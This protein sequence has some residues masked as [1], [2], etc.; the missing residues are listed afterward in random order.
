MNDDD[1]P[2]FPGVLILGDEAFDRIVAD[3]EKPGK[4]SAGNLRGAEFLR[5]Y[6]ELQRAPKLRH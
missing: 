3:M 1:I 2:E 6:G 5:Q 4:P